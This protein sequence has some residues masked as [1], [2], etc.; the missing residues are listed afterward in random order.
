[1]LQ[2]KNSFLLRCFKEWILDDQSL[3]NETL[4]GSFLLE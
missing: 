2:W 3:S 4:L 1:M